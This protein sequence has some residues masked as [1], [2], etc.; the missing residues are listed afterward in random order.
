MSKRL[1]HSWRFAVI[2]QR[3][4]KAETGDPE[5]MSSN[6]REDSSIE[7]LPCGQGYGG[8]YTT[9]IARASFILSLV[10]A[11]GLL[12]SGAIWRGYPHTARANSPG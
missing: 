9:A 2:L 10:L 11:T 4:E 3:R 12:A 8:R 5:P 1:D 7:E 6:C